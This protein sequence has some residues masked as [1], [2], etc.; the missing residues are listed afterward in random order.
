MEIRLSSKLA[1]VHKTHLNIQQQQQ[2]QSAERDLHE[3][4]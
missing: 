2:K 3:Y 1:S 4:I